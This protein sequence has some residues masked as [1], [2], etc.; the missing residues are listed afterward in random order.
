[1][2]YTFIQYL[3]SLPSNYKKGILL[4]LDALAVV[5]GLWFSISLRYGEFYIAQGN[6]WWLFFITPFIAWAVFIK[7]GLYRAIVRYLS[8]HAL[9][10]IVLAISLFIL[11]W[12]LALVMLNLGA[13]KVP[14]SVPIIYWLICLLVIG[15]SRLIARW[16]FTAF[17]RKNENIK[18]ILIYGVGSAGRQLSLSLGQ[19]DEFNHVAYVDDDKSLQGRYLQGKPVYSFDKIDSLIKDR[20]VTEILIAMP[21]LSR[22]QRQ[23]LINNLE[24]YGLKVQVVPGIDKIASGELNINDIQDVDIYD[25]LQRAPV[26]PIS[27][28]L[29]KNITNKNVLVTGAGGSIGAEICRQALKLNPKVLVL[30]ELSEFS[31]YNI[32]KELTEVNKSGISIKSILGNIQDVD[33]VDGVFFRY[34]INTIYHAAAYKHV[35]MVESNPLVGLRNNVL[36]TYNLSLAADKYKT[37][38]FVLISTDK[39]VRSTSI[40]GASKRLC[41]LILQAMADNSKT[42]FSMVRF[43]NVL[44]SSGSV[45]PLFRQQILEGGPLTVTH[46][47]ITRFFMLI[48]EA[49]E[50]V[51]QAGAMAKGGEVFVLDMGES[52]KIDHLARRMI[53][54]S[55]LKIQDESNLEGDIEIKYTGLR[56][57]EKLYEELL[58]G[59]NNLPTVHPKIM[60]AKEEKL[61]LSEITDYVQDIKT[62]KNSKKEVKAFLKKVVVGYNPQDNI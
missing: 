56:E 32:K 57:A 26:A 35:P 38:T 1:M 6:I 58:I 2:F 5:F 33:T 9:Y 36:G 46:R 21:S 16:I 25:L 62:L 59:D 34:A 11:A 45:I 61:K 51:V 7:L 43:G 8:F 31:L 39:A 50:L 42:V 30:L 40:M 37:E 60:C 28:L 48:P 22:L 53:H 12:S 23:K 55:G 27:E 13:D 24:P 44:D 54:L 14:R 20:D 15:G 52:I 41:E 4:L 29:H 3:S 17:S 18:N 10:T 47:A 19:S 49:V